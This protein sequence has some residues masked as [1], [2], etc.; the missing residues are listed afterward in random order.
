MAAPHRVLVVDDGPANRQLLTRLLTGEGY[1]VHTVGD[2]EGALASLRECPP[3][4]VLLD[5]MLPGVNGFDV[6]RHIKNN[7][8]TCLTPVVLITGLDASKHRLEGIDAG[9][10]EFLTKPF[11]PVELKARVR[12]LIRVKR[13]TDELESAESVILS[14][15]MTIEAR[16]PYTDGHCQRLAGYATALGAALGCTDDEL[17][18]LQRGGYLHDVGKVGVSDTVLNKPGKLTA[19]EYELMKRHPVIGD[20]LCGGMRSLASVRLIVRSHHERLD[21]SGYPDGLRGD[22]I[23]I[24]AQ[25][26]AVADVYDALTTSRPYRGA[27]PSD[28][29]CRVLLEEA[30]CHKHS[31]ERVRVFVSL[32]EAGTL[33]SPGTGVL[34]PTDQSYESPERA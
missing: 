18:A 29:A 31:N 34:S 23:P 28:V 20:R 5:V 26:V 30:R 24:V 21:G 33:V 32:V 22:D 3:D 9:A 4:I 14:L 17:A 19:A 11:D 7:P 16:D 8:A 12:S 27:L 6:C 25:I 15:A 1:C 10:D 2:G 13:F